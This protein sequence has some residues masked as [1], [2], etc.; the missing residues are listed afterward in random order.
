M[1]RRFMSLALATT[2]LATPAASWAQD[3]AETVYM[4]R[5]LPL[6][7]TAGE[8]GYR[9]QTTSAFVDASGNPIDEA[10]FCGDAV[11]R[12][13]SICIN[14]QTNA[15]VGDSFC[16]AKP[17]STEA[18]FI[19]TACTFSWYQGAW[20][21]PGASCGSEIQSRTVQCQNQSGQPVAD[22]FCDGA[23]PAM[24]QSVSDYSGCSG[25]SSNISVAWGPWTQ[26]STCS[27]TATRSRTGSC[28]VD[29]AAAPDSACTSNGFALTETQPSPNYNS[30]TYSWK[31]GA[32]FDPG[33]SC[34][35]NELQT[36]SVTCQRDLDSAAVD[37][38]YCSR[39]QT[40]PVATQSVQDFSNCTYTPVYGAWGTCTNGTQTQSMTGCT[41]EDGASVAT[42]SC[43]TSPAT[44][45]RSCESEVSG[46]CSSWQGVRTYRMQNP[47]QSTRFE[48]AKST[49]EICADYNGTSCAGD[50]DLG[51]SIESNG[52]SYGYAEYQVVYNGAIHYLN[53]GFVN[54]GRAVSTNKCVSPDGSRTYNG[55]NLGPCAQI[56][57]VTSSTVSMTLGGTT[58]TMTTQFSGNR[59]VVASVSTS[60]SGAGG[61][62]TPAQS[63]NLEQSC[64]DTMFGQIC[65]DKKYAGDS[66]RCAGYMNASNFCS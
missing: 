58:Y 16:G 34:S 37:D 22:S 54:S 13:T 51:T 40:K 17:A 55:A 1:L 21:D 32:W 23:R 66:D 46:Q 44:K 31:E 49:G 5:P 6:Q 7:P 28:R 48:D 62:C 33:A 30:C 65:N 42:S 61:Q 45:S 52:M 29:G 64:V 43:S 8:A 12:N 14:T 41:R 24:T 2:M 15:Q 35:A 11:K 39:T 25:S 10:N 19:G 47:V 56:G 36:R 57:G 38:V 27:A 63:S 20:N 26:S 9:W 59:S 3:E 4:R 53:S 18:Q 60:G 50:S